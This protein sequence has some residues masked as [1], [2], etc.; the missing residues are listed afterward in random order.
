M[1]KPESILIRHL[2][3]SR[4]RRATDRTGSSV[5]QIFFLIGSVGSL[6]LDLAGA[7]FLGHCGDPSQRFFLGF[8]YS[9]SS[10][11]VLSHDL[12]A[13]FAVRAYEIYFTLCHFFN[14]DNTVSPSIGNITDGGEVGE[15]EISI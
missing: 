14:L 1:G 10:F 3:I 5:I 6:D 7:V 13:L 2:A 8:Q 4:R 9:K 12:P 11:R 15:N